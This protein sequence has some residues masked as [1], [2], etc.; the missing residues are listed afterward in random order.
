MSCVTHTHTHIFC[1]SPLVHEKGNPMQSM[2]ISNEFCHLPTTGN[3]L[4]K[5]PSFPGCA[6][7]PE[8]A[9]F[10]SCALPTARTFFLQ[11]KFH[12]LGH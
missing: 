4:S 11:A 10:Q 3:L 6:Q 5:A 7:L 8:A 9:E 1:L 12:P 2:F